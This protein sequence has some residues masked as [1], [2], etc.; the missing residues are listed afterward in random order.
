MKNLIFAAALTAALAAVGLD[1]DTGK[2][3]NQGV[4]PDTVKLPADKIYPQGRLF[5]FTFYSTGGGSME[6]RG[7]LL[8]DA[9]READTQE[10]VRGGVTMI[11]PQYELNDQV[12]ATARKYG[13]K[14]VYTVHPVIDGKTLNRP[15]LL[16]LA[17]DDP[18]HYLERIKAAMAKLIREQAKNPEIAWWDVSPEEPR[19]W[20]APEVAYI[21]AAYEVIK[22]NDPLKRPVFVYEPGHRGAGSLAKFLPYQ[23]LSV[24]GTY[25]NYSG[26][27]NSRAWV[28]HSIEQE[29]TAIKLAK[30]P[31]VVPIALLEMFQQPK[32][33]EM[34]LIRDW[35]R[36]DVYCSLVSGAKGIMVFSA[37]K[38][39]KFTA[40][41]EYLKAYLEVCNELNGKQQL[42]QIFLFGKPMTDLECVI[43]E[44]D[45]TIEAKCGK[46][47]KKL[48]AVSFA[49]Y[50]WNNRRYAFAVNST[51]K[52]VKI[53]IS[54]LVYGSGVTVR[55][56]FDPELEFTAPEGDFEYTLKP[57]EAAGFE[58]FLNSK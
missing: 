7:K 5:P 36:H 35:V 54:G 37:S 52:P 11:G 42:G 16:Q 46:E 38:R 9:E 3:V 41:P 17:K 26:H 58:I 31:G 27:R 18:E 51:Q 24:K 4:G 8:P 53:I 13:V 12:A 19:F 48:P 1:T 28:R 44:G 30:R 55:G 49:S 23:D 20:I 57:Y 2:F 14:A 25:T 32:P 15:L 6:K 29:T 34:K 43:V 33:E 45:E 21:Q 47:M 39:P 56:I 40:R 22:A 10:I 50:A